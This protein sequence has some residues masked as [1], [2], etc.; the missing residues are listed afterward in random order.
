MR[1]VKKYIFNSEI[2]Q[3]KRLFRQRILKYP[4]R[5]G[6]AALTINLSIVTNNI[7]LIVF[8]TYLV[9]SFW[10]LSRGWN[11]TILDLHGFRQTQTAISTFYLIRGSS[12]LAYETPVLGAPWSLPFEFPIY[13]WL[14][15]ILVKTF[16]TPLDQTGRFVSVIFF[17]FSLIPSYIILKCLNIPRSYRWMFLSLFLASPL[18]LF[19]SRTF[20]IESTALFF[21]L[22]YLAAVCS[23]FTKK[24]L[25]FAAFA[26]LFGVLAA[27]VKITT[28]AG[29]ILAAS[30]VTF[31]DWQKR[32]SDIYYSLVIPAVAFALLPYIAIST[33]TQFADS[34]KLLNPIAADFITSK[35][36]NAWNFGNL[37]Q[38]LSPQLLIAIGRTLSDILGWRPVIGLQLVI[39]ILLWV[40]LLFLGKRNKLYIAS[41]SVFI[42]VIL[43]FTNLH[44]V[45]NYYAYANGIFVIAAIGFGILGL[46][47]RIDKS[48]V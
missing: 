31:F 3:L 13:Q 14:T 45:H 37:Q 30:L 22:A 25:K 10:A 21:C 41:L 5:G 24:T 42:A 29:F 36:L 18:Y 15:A 43:V 17:Y 6:V 23:Y 39:F 33:W 19:W 27:L 16:G 35:A 40:A 46:L 12:W 4:L 34:Q 28:F 47:E 48:N 9:H 20:M 11:N 7:F 8:L 2:L 38:R 44:V 26:I 1:S 32:R